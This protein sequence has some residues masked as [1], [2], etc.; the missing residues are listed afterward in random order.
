MKIAVDSSVWI[1]FLRSQRDP[2]VE[3]VQELLEADALVLL[4]PVEVELWLGSRRQERSIL[5]ELFSVMEYREPVADSWT[6]CRRVARRTRERGITF[7][8]VDLLI[9]GT[10]AEHARGS[11]LLWTLDRDFEPLFRSTDLRRYDYIQ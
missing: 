7:S 3:H 4:A 9:A 5:S 6:W 8:P 2:L 1:E 11:L 10:C